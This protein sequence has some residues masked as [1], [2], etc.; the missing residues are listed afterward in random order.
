MEI[1]RFKELEENS[2]WCYQDND[3]IGFMLLKDKEEEAEEYE[4]SLGTAKKHYK[5]KFKASIKKHILNTLSLI[6]N[7]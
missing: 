2:Y 7:Q 5:M 3:T 1:L 4:L 6:T